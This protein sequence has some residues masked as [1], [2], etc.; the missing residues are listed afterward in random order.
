MSVYLIAKISIK[1]RENYARYEEG[2]M[3]IWSRYQGK[4]LV[5]DEQPEVLEGDWD[6][7]RT[8]LLEF[9]GEA[10]AKAWYHSDEYQALA[11]HRF[12]SSDGN[13]VLVKGFD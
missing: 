6:C 8:V 11:E 3:D 7:T 1:D 13:I 9:P 5:V 12:A 4:L 10:E 2:F